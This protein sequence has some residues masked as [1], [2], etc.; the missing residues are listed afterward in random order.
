MR[1]LMMVMLVMLVGCGPQLGE[2]DCSFNDVD[3]YCEDGYVLIDQGDYVALDY[4]G[5][6]EDYCPLEDT[7][8]P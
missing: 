1:N 2:P 4:E 5:T 7:P 6:C 8:I 3:F